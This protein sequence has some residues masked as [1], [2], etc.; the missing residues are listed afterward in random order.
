MKR[1]SLIAHAL[2]AWSTA[3]I[4][5]GVARADVVID[6]NSIMQSTVASSNA[7]IQSRNAAITQLAVFEAV[8]TITK[9]FPP[10]LGTVWGAHGASVDAAAIAAA[11]RSLVTLHPAAA[12]T[13]DGAYD[14]AIQALPD[15]QSRLDGI[16]V[17][18]AAANAMLALRAFDGAAAV[19]SYVAGTDPGD[20]QRTP[21]SFLPPLLPNWGQVAT[22]G[23]D[24]GAQYRAGL[25]PDL[26]SHKYA[27]DYVEVATVGAVDSVDRPQRLT[28]V[29]NFYVIPAVQVYNPAARQVS[30]VQNRTLSENAQAFA[31]LNMAIADA[32]ITNFESKYYYNRWRPVTAIRAGDTD[33]NRRTQPDATWLPLIVT[34][35][36]PSYPSAHASAGGAARAVLEEL[37]G[38]DGFDITLTSTA[39]P[40]VVLHYTSWEQIT[41]DID[42]ARVYG[43]IHFRYDQDAGARQGREVGSDIVRIYLRGKP[44]CDN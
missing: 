8:N 26:K 2:A 41:D 40:T 21:P 1:S 10:Y 11:H 27:R 23:I 15:T 39:A 20:W 3:L 33:G 7:L 42:D 13:L 24:S 14:T 32:L 31:V 37:Y 36:F 43:G 38:K 30:A 4:L 19:V 12:S 25:P 44:A 29:A 6:W 17:G 9:R 35:P 18:E 28:D 16:A 22:F 5:T 34:P